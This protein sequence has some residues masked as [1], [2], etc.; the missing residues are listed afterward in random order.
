MKDH[1][2][3]Y[4]CDLVVVLTK[5]Y[6]G[7]VSVNKFSLILLL[8]AECGA[9]IIEFSRFFIVSLLALP[10][11]FT[12]AEHFKPCMRIR[13]YLIECY[14]D[15]T[16]ISN[17]LQLTPVLCPPNVDYVIPVSSKATVWTLLVGLVI[18]HSK[19]FISVKFGPCDFLGT[20]N[21]RINILMTTILH[22]P[23][24]I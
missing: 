5:F 7:W 2:S 1:E 8:S 6:L 4:L 3:F 12:E 13:L 18:L 9:R 10:P 24:T 11:T 21:C 20:Q 15:F 23:L 16:L 14:F 22:Q 19:L 17:S